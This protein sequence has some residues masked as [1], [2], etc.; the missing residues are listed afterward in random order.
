MNKIP[1]RGTYHALLMPATIHGAFTVCRLLLCLLGH[2]SSHSRTLARVFKDEIIASRKQYR[3][4]AFPRALPARIQNTKLQTAPTG[5]F[6]FP[7]LRSPCSLVCDCRLTQ[8]LRPPHTEY[9][10][11]CPISIPPPPETPIVH[12]PLALTPMGEHSAPEPERRAVQPTTVI[13]S[14]GTILLY[15]RETR[16]TRMGERQI[17]EGL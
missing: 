1:I 7:F 16:G 4:L 9:C 2:L 3:P 12:L 17:E 14:D 13:W 15:D 6:P 11:A 5:Y 10:I 8:L